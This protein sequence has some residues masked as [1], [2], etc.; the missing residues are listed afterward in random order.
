MSST[1][2]T[3]GAVIYTDGGAKPNPGFIGW[4]MH[5]YLY[6]TEP[7]KQ[8]P[9]ISNHKLTDRGYVFPN[10][11]TSP[12]VTPIQ[13]YDFMG[14]KLGPGTNNEAE[15]TALI[16]SLKE[17]A[18]EKI[19]QLQVFSDSDYLVKG[20]KDGI[21]NWNRYNWKKPNGDPVPNSQLWQE[22][23]RLLTVYASKHIEV[24]VEWV[25]GHAD[26]FG[27]ILADKLASIAV[28]YSINQIDRIIYKIT[29]AKGYW[30]KDIDKHPFIDHKRLYFNSDSSYNTAGHYFLAKPGS[31]DSVIGKKN[32]DAGY[33][34][35]RLKQP[36]P[37]LEI[38][39]AFQSDISD[40]M[41]NI[42]V[43]RLDKVFNPEVYE[44]I[45]EHGYQA[46]SRASKY[47]PAVN[48]VDNKPLTIIQNP[49][50]LCLRAIQC[51]GIL[52]ELLDLYLANTQTGI[53]V[54]DWPN[55]KFHNI[56]DIFYQSVRKRNNMTEGEVE[57]NN[58][59]GVG[60]S[61]LD[62]PVTVEHNNS[63]INLKV[64][65]SLGLDLPNRNSLKRI[66]KLNPSV[67]LLTW[68]EGS[69]CFRYASV[70]EI[71]DAI[72]VWSNYYSNQ[73]FI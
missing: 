58:R 26:S 29:P 63:P 18:K 56:T 2:H 57:L 65:L 12:I 17:L 48:Y 8:G 35:I 54:Y 3:L 11:V 50:G 9:G 25:K 42:V 43:M 34:V 62:V 38:V 45:N 73:I 24:N 23:E 22:I 59:F 5:G 31:D 71:D 10:K 61:Q 15:L 69:R 55:V 47:N 16:H 68:Q 21:A 39:K 33:S 32:P 14:S 52:E 1:K 41:N 13:Y 27:N 6:T 49:P 51:S 72:G 66:E 20:I 67:N 40:D 36:D 37:V 30:K 4:G 44:T 28:N 19:S 60:F 70:V 7:A 53:S 64:C 46:M